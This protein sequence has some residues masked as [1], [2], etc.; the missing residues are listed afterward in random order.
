MEPQRHAYTPSL[1][2]TSSSDAHAYTPSL[3]TTG[4][5]DAASENTILSSYQEPELVTPMSFDYHMWHPDAIQFSLPPSQ[6]HPPQHYHTAHAHPHHN[7]STAG[8]PMAPDPAYFYPTS[9]ATTTR[10]P[11]IATEHTYVV[12]YNSNVDQKSLNSYHVD[13]NA[14]QQMMGPGSG[15]FFWDDEEG[16]L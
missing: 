7:V 9:T 14:G 11:S 13:N 12:D 5:S 10:T 8:F 16:G 3:G 2:G 15:T 6:H 1:G 4:S